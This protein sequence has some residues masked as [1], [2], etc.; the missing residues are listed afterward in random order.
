VKVLC[1]LKRTF[2]LLEMCSNQRSPAIY[3]AGAIASTPLLQDESSKAVRS[4]QLDLIALL[5]SHGISPDRNGAQGVRWA[6]K[7]AKFEVV[8]LLLQGTISPSSASRA[9]DSI[10]NQFSEERLREL[11]VILADIGASAES[12][13]R[14]LARVVDNGF[15]SVPIILVDRGA[16]IDCDN[17]RSVRSLLRA[18]DIELL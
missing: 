17:A 3:S 10:P 13:G 15:K 14:C 18:H 2:S 6:L 9:L 16:S 7:E 12:F 4:M 11:V 5:I 1:D 8:E